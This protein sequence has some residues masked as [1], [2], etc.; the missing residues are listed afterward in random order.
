MLSLEDIL[1]L[2]FLQKNQKMK[3]KS[4]QWRS[5]LG[6]SLYCSMILSVSFAAPSMSAEL[7]V[8][9]NSSILYV[10][11]DMMMDDLPFFTKLI[12][13]DGVTAVA[14]DSDGGHLESGIQMGEVIRSK[15]LDTII[16]KDRD[17]ASSCAIAFIHGKSRRMEIGSRLGLHL[18]SVE[19]KAEDTK[20]FCTQIQLD[21]SDGEVDLLQP[22]DIQALTFGRLPRS[23]IANTY[24][25]AM[26]DAVFFIELFTKL[27]IGENVLIDMLKTAPTEMKW[28]TVEQSSAA[29]LLTK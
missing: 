4:C 22:L 10:M 24:G 13:E 28:Y 12:S 3:M 29:G 20:A 26:K 18:P 8:P 16:L 17:C 21:K 15:G 7:L 14:F 2:K 9:P 27:N 25:L 1:A 23:C 6:K 11:G 5:E 19:L